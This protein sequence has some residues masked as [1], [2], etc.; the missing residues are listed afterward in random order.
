MSWPKWKS[1]TWR[2]SYNRA[3]AASSAGAWRNPCGIAWAGA[4]RPSCSSTAGAAPQSSSAGTVATWCPA[5]AVRW[6]LPTIPWT[7]VC[8]ATGA[9]GAAG[10]PAVAGNA[11]AA[12]SASW[13]SAP[14]RWWRRCP[15]CYRACGLSGGTPTPPAPAPGPGTPCR[16]WPLVIYRSWWAPRWWPKAST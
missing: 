10:C 2:W 9:T 16:G 1:A 12:T 13:A 6:P 14:R 7:A 11:E 3:T 8:C 15:A 5:G 4:G